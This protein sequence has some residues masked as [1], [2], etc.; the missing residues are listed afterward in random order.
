[1]FAA[2]AAAAEGSFASDVAFAVLACIMVVLDIYMVADL[3][4]KYKQYTDKKKFDETVV[5]HL[6]RIMGEYMDAYAGKTSSGD[7]GPDPSGE[8]RREEHNVART[9]CPPACVWHNSAQDQAPFDRLPQKEDWTIY[10]R[11][12]VAREC[13]SSEA[14]ACD[15][16]SCVI[17]VAASPDL[18]PQPEPAKQ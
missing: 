10:R 16:D 12:K 9:Q 8:P 18:K 1:M 5:A 2:T 13:L 4:I 7:S 11:G 15:S 17:D 6:M 3:Y 14:R